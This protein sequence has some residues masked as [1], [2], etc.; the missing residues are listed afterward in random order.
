MGVVTLVFLNTPA[1]VQACRYFTR[2]FH[3]IRTATDPCSNC[4]TVHVQ[5][6]GAFSLNPKR[7]KRQITGRPYRCT[8]E[9]VINILLLVKITAT[10]WVN[11]LYAY[12]FT[13]FYI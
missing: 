2:G 4:S 5:L 6:Y 1:L 13:F 8:E 10:W 3:H 7:H 9:K 12:I 11:V